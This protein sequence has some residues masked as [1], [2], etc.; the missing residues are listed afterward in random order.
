MLNVVG[1]FTTRLPGFTNR[2]FAVFLEN[3]LGL[4]TSA[5]A[6]LRCFQSFENYSR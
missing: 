1:A 5:N 3:G 2:I 4:S 6:S